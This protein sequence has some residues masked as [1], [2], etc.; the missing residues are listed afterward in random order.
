MQLIKYKNALNFKTIKFMAESIEVSFSFNI[1]DTKT[2]PLEWVKFLEHSK[3]R[4]Q[5]LMALFFLCVNRVCPNGTEIG[6]DFYE[7]RI[8]K[9]FN[10]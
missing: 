9:S 10:K 4:K 7:N 1:L 5:T 2:V 6:V 3:S 8:C